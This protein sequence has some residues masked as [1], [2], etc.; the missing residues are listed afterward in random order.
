M[1][2]YVTRGG[3]IVGAYWLSAQDVSLS[4]TCPCWSSIHLLTRGGARFRWDSIICHICCQRI[5][6][7]TVKPAWGRE[8]FIP[9]MFLLWLTG[10][11][12]L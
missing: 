7:D 8:V 3:R 5:R 4:R 2:S 9:L 6:K 1:R 11:G 10:S 12:G